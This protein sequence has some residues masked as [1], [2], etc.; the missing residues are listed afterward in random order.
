MRR[1]RYILSGH[2]FAFLTVCSFAVV[3]NV[4]GAIVDPLITRFLIDRV[5]RREVE[6]LIYAGLILLAS[7][8]VLRLGLLAADL[9]VSRT[10]NRVI[11][12]LV[13]RTLVAYFQLDYLTVEN[14]GAGYFVSRLYDEPVQVAKGLLTGCTKFITAVATAAGSLGICMYLSWRLT[15]GL[16]V[17]VPA[18]YVTSRR[19][20]ERLRA[21]TVGA[22]EQEGTFKTLFTR[23]L[24]AYLTVKLFNLQSKSCSVVLERLDQVLATAYKKVS[25][26]R[27]VLTISSILLSLS[28]GVVFVAGAFAVVRGDLSIGGLVAF[29]SA[30]WRLINA[31]GNVNTAIPEMSSTMACIDRLIELESLPKDL[32]GVQAPEADTIVLSNV[33]VAYGGLMVANDLS[34]RISPGE[35]VLIVGRNGCGKTTLLR[36]LLGFLCPAHGSLA[37]PARARVSAALSPGPFIPGTLLDNVDFPKLDENQRRLLDALASELDISDKLETDVARLSAGQRQKCRL[38]MAFLKDADY[39]FLDEPFTSVDEHSKDLLMSRIMASNSTVIAVMHGDERFHS[40]FD[41][42]IKP[43][44]PDVK[45]SVNGTAARELRRVGVD[46]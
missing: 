35:K 32:E 4:V 25:T 22:N 26:A 13:K 14:G 3:V 10:Q 27:G 41:R 15:V 24:D 6:Q 43:F 33:G 5:L 19:M 11:R 30:F 21:A 45:D 7:G 40:L 8:I 37:G 9:L 2:F 29:M 12:A 1:F 31:A 39:L 28:E 18:M 16:L 23:T 44:G 34:L 46:A 42:V 38:I 36:L 20:R 17:I